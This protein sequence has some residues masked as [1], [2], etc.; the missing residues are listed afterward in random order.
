MK[1]INSVVFRVYCIFDILL[2]L[3]VLDGWW[4]IKPKNNLIQLSSNSSIYIKI[5][6]KKINLIS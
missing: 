2:N 5:V 6:I 4:T 1:D 3:S